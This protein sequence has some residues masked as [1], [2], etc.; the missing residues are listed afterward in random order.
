[1]AIQGRK[2]TS[3][4]SYRYGFNGKEND[5]ESGTIDFGARA[6]DARLGRWLSID[7]KV[8][9][10]E[11][12]YVGMA[13]GPIQFKDVD[14]RDVIPIVFPDYKIEAGVLGKISGLGHAGVLIIDNKT[15]VTSYY[16]Y[17][18][19][20]SE[21]KGLARKVTCS[22]VVI[23]AN[24]KPTLESLNKVLG[25]ISKNSGHSGP[26]VGVYIPDDNASDMVAYAE[27]RV[28]EISDDNRKEYSLKNN[29]CGTFMD[30]VVDAGDNDANVK[31][32]S[33]ETPIELILEYAK[34]D[35]YDKVYYNPK[36][37]ITS[38]GGVTSEAK[39]KAPEVKAPESAKKTTKK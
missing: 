22:D 9:P 14:G 17:G 10:Y 16:E 37:K 19:Y 3:S 8:H 26:I 36:S 31:P 24:G 21:Q 39:A 7:P 32:S 23:G 6:Y 18:R 11:S 5:S 25:Q 20:D 4:S 30:A 27:K 15:G 2:Y 28:A 38:V 33:Y 1:M 13:N 35:K 34:G 29:N 12:P